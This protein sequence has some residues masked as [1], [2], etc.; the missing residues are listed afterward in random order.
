MSPEAGLDSASER[1][2]ADEDDDVDPN[3][4]NDDRPKYSWASECSR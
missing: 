2:D 1:C 3:V 4:S